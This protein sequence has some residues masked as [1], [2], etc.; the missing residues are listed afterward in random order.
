MNMFKG[1]TIAAALAAATTVAALPAQAAVISSSSYFSDDTGGFYAQ[2]KTGFAYDYLFD[3]TTP[4]T[5]A[6]T[7][8][9]SSVTNPITFTSFKLNDVAYSLV[10][11]FEKSVTTTGISYSL[12]S[13]FSI[14]AGSQKISIA[15]TGSNKATT[16]S[17]TV[18]FVSLV[19]EPAA[20]MMMVV[21]FGALGAVMRRRPV[22]GA[23][24]HA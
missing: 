13:P 3:V 20:W 4:G 22:A 19:P 8:T 24:V 5:L 12:I 21:G 15:G 11:F 9:S 7:L 10:D 17:G 16:L 2:V 14:D 23:I 6:F 1:L 18:S